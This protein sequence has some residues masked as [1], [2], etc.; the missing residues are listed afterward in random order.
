ME[1]GWGEE[2]MIQCEGRQLVQFIWLLKYINR[3]G[4]VIGPTVGVNSPNKF[5]DFCVWRLMTLALLTALA[6]PAG[7]WALAGP[8]EDCSW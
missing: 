1:G 2:I 5:C 6:P 4:D 7:H 3:I 8:G